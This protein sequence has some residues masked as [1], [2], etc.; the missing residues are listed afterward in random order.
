MKA[1]DLKALLTNIDDEVEICVYEGDDLETS[2]LR[3]AHASGIRLVQ[4]RTSSN[5]VKYFSEE[6]DF[7]DSEAIVFYHRK[8]S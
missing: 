1:K 8:L 4:E 2:I 6:G 5:K 3:P 7:L